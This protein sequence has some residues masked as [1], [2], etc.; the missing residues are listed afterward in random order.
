M[1]NRSDQ[2]ACYH[3]FGPEVGF[4]LLP[5]T[6]LDFIRTQYIKYQ[7]H[8]SK[9]TLCYT[10][11]IRL[12]NVHIL[13]QADPQQKEVHTQLIQLNSVNPASLGPDNQYRIILA[14]GRYLTIH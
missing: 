14:T 1:C 5:S 4:Y 3:I 9:A 12:T 8:S 10:D 7:I 6:W 13:F 2:P 11:R